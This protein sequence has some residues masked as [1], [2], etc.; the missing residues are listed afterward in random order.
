MLRSPSRSRLVVILALLL[1]GLM[2]LIPVPALAASGAAV[3]AGTVGGANFQLTDAP[4]DGVAL[5]WS[6]GSVQTSYEIVRVANTGTTVLPPD[7]GLPATAT[8]YRDQPPSTDAIDCYLLVPIAGET[9]LGVSDV[10]CR[11]LHLQT[12]VNA[13]NSFGLSVTSSSTTT[14]SWLPPAVTTSYVLESLDPNGQPGSNYSMAVLPSFATA[15]TAT[16]TSQAACYVLFTVNDQVLAGI[17]DML[18]AVTGVATL[19]GTGAAAP[20]TARSVDR[21]AQQLAAI[22]SALPTAASNRANASR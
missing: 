12:A 4:L 6:G 10:L 2:P 8:A 15:T 17:S 22:V 19:T 5:S 3:P 11:A 13:P 18:C 1:G 9:P 16:P 7:G 14:L 21:V 20:T